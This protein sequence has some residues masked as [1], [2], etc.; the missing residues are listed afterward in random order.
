[1]KISVSRLLT[2]NIGLK[3][4]SLLLAIFF[5]YYVVAFLNP[6]TE[7]TI[8][9][10]PIVVSNYSMLT[11]H[12]L[13][14]SNSIDD[15]DKSMNIT[16]RGPRSM[17]KRAN[18]KNISVIADL[19]NY[20]SVGTHVIP[21]NIQ[22]PSADLSVV[23]QTVDN[24]SVNIDT[25]ATKKFPVLVVQ[26]GKMPADYV[27]YSHAPSV[28]EVTISGAQNTLLTIDR[29]EVPINLTGAT[30][31][32][33]QTNGYKLL[34]GNDVEITNVELNISPEQVS[35]TAE[36]YY[37]KTVPVQINATNADGKTIDCPD[38]VTL[39]GTKDVLDN[40]SSVATVEFNVSY[41]K[42]RVLTEIKLDL[43]AGVLQKDKFMINVIE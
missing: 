22:L 21:L 29:V 35:V 17:V 14:V 8:Y 33:T 1:M 34:S 27:L 25:L 41:I 6:Q 12:S 5:W 32:F 24:F 42:R 13:V 7:A 20:L 40:I 39:F 4:L 11:E 30:A 16:I 36:V 15:S 9:N 28:G 2:R 31:S 19:S 43:P 18:N 38:E 37:A 23:K 26:E 3:L 10:V